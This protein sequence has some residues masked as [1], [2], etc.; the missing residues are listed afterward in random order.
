MFERWRQRRL[1]RKLARAEVPSARAALNETHQAIESL[2]SD[3]MREL[4]ALVDIPRCPRCGAP[5]VQRTAHKGRN[6]GSEFWGCRTYP[7]CTYSASLSEYA[8]TWKPYASR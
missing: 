7:F 4:S 1:F 3:S 6:P 2:R 5:L 8:E